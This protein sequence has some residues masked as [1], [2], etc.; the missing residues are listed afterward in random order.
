MKNENTVKESVIHISG[1]Y[2][3]RTDLLGYSSTLYIHTVFTC[4][5]NEVWHI[6]Y[7]NVLIQET[8]SAANAQCKQR[9]QR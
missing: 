5:N 9:S 3:Q 8:G 7:N 4:M 1:S 2:V 6:H